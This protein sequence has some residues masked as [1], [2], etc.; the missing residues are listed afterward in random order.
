[1][2]VSFV[3]FV[4]QIFEITTT[5]RFTLFE[6]L[7]FRRGVQTVMLL[8]MQLSTAFS[9]SSQVGPNILLEHPQSCNV[10]HKILHTYKTPDKNTD[11]AF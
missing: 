6:R 11:Y 2:S 9:P 8:I 4:K 10:S 7:N 1:M 3:T 5:M